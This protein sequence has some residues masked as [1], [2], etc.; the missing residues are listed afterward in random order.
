MLASIAESLAEAGLNVE[1]LTTE[2]Q[3]HNS[4]SHSGRTDFVVTA[5]CVTSQK[6]SKEQIQAMVRRL[7]SI[8]DMLVLDVV[9]IRVQHRTNVRD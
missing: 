6:M 8:K 2:L 7:E 9:D 3:R 5:D 1:S 4:F